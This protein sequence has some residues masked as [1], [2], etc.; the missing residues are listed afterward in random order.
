[1]KKFIGILLFTGYHSLPQEQLYWCEDEDMDV[2][3]VRKCMSR[4]RYLK[5]KRYLHLNDNSVLEKVPADDRD[6]LF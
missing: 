3:Y 5:I 6:R 2:Q 1:M 4:N